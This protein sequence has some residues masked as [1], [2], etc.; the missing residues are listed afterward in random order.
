MKRLL[1]LTFFLLPASCADTPPTVTPA[2]ATESTGPAPP[3]P[4]AEPVSL[5]ISNSELAVG[6]ERIAFRMYD[7][8]GNELIGDTYDV[9]VRDMTIFADGFESGDTSAW[10]SSLPRR[11]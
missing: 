3:T 10:S 7:E 4:E 6:Q 2:P 11:P 9:E 1:L 8:A 5:E